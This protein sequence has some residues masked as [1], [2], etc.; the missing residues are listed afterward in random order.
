MSNCAFCKY[1]C[2]NYSQSLELSRPG[3]GDDCLAYGWKR[4]EEVCSTCQRYQEVTELPRHERRAVMITIDQISLLKTLVEQF[5]NNQECSVYVATLLE[6]LVEVLDKAEDQWY[7]I[8]EP[9]YDAQQKRLWE[10]SQEMGKVKDQPYENIF[11]R[12]GGR[13]F[14]DFVQGATSQQ[15]IRIVPFKRL[16]ISKDDPKAV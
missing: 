13:Y 7:D 12:D 4:C 15:P 5:Q 1:N 2:Q 14:A 6:D 8:Y 3:Q 10:L 16:S 9:E 11:V